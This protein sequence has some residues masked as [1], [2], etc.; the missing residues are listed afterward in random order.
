MLCFNVEKNFLVRFASSSVIFSFLFYR[1]IL[2]FQRENTIQCMNVER[3]VAD[4]NI[5][6]GACSKTTL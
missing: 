3:T 6:T 2:R 4:I 1:I 5:E